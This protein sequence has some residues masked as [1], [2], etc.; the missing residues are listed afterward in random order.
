MGLFNRIIISLIN[1]I[2]NN[3][4]KPIIRRRKIMRYNV[5]YTLYLDLKFL[6]LII[7]PIIIQGISLIMM[8]KFFWL[9]TTMQMGCCSI[10][11]II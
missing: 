6:F 4:N 2:S 5:S 8:D 7:M 3:F 9:I 11:R 10:T 1:H